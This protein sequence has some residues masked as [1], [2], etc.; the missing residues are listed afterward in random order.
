M[1]LGWAHVAAA[2]LT[3]L[4]LAPVL[5]A[6]PRPHQRGADGKALLSFG[7]RLLA[8]AL[9]TVL[10]SSSPSKVRQLGSKTQLSA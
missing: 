5:I 6:V 3:A 4:I 7:P 1:A 2:L 10:I 9:G 8:G